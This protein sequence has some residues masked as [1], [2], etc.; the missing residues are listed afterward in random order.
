MKARRGISPGRGQKI[1]GGQ[2]IHSPVTA[3]KK[4]MEKGHPAAR[5]DYSCLDVELN[6][7]IQFEMSDDERKSKNP[8]FR[9]KH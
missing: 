6:L 8:G 2:G 7:T 4:Y 5:L 9:G 3:H 1:G